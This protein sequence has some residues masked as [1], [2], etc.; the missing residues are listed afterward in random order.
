MLATVVWLIVLTLS[1]WLF[2]K[3]SGSLSPFKPN[4]N[5]LIFY[6][7]LVASSYI[8]SLLIVLDVD[9]YYMINKL[10][11]E[12]IRII[13]FTAISFVMI[14]LPL[15]MF[16]VS[17]LVGFNAKQEFTHYLQKPI[18]DMFS[19][20]RGRKEFYFL[21][22][23]LSLISILAVAYT[24]LKTNQVPLFELLKG[25]V[26]ELGRLR[27]EAAR[28]FN[29]NIYIRNIF[30]IALTPLLSLIAYV[31]AVKTKELKWTFLWWALFGCAVIISVYDLAKSPIIFYIIMF[32]FVR[33]YVG[34]LVLDNESYIRTEIIYVWHWW[35]CPYHF[36]VRLYSRRK[37]YWYFLIL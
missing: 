10:D 13:G 37:R 33:M 8:G 21:F 2:S 5:S 30:A 11:H 27:I 12:Y 36:D 31:C 35:C 22:L 3:V 14:F 4:L 25:N 6:Y 29:G 15:T 1:T 19:D 32:I 28:N 7:S 23:A 24:L 26:A 20:K 16:L 17:T 9:H 18:D 34:N